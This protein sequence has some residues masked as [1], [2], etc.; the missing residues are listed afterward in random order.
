VVRGEPVRDDV[1]M[2]ADDLLGL[3]RAEIDASVTYNGAPVLLSGGFFTENYAFQL[4]GAP[5]RW[6]GPLVVRLFPAVAPPDLAR[7]EA[8]VQ[9]F[10]AQAGYPAPDVLLFDDNARL[11]DRRF[12]VMQRLPGRAM[13]GGLGPRELAMSGWQMFGRIPKV[14][15]SLQARL[16]RIDP[17][18]LEA[19]L[20]DMPAGIERWF[21]VLEQQIARG[22]EGLSSGLQ[23]LVD[24][25]PPESGGRALNHGDLWAGNILAVGRDV[26]GVIDYTVAT[27][28][29]P[30]LDV[31]FTTMGLCLAP[32]DA[33]PAIQRAAAWLGERI[34]ARY[35]RAYRS[36]SDADLSN[37]PYYEALRCATEL[38]QVVEYR[39][40]AAQGEAAD[41][42]LPT[43]DSIAD[44]MVEYF[45]ARTGVTL[46]LPPRGN[47]A[48][49]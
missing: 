2:L 12:F 43:W 22:Y 33:P 32:I 36:E 8:A 13:L 41:I 17:G 16:H 23:W 38:S 31:G 46:E 26:T 19:E 42:P 20:G 34:S 24:H 28:A 18:P 21:A 14:T 29:D 15:A 45:R 4:A 37:Q 35:L 49:A 47:A 1:A 27:I 3:L 9:R 30:A 11:M 48:G 44:T 25:R 5:T 7:R 40:A 6:S 39:L 10:L